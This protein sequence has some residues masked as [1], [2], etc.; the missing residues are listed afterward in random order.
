LVEEFE[1]FPL[2]ETVDLLDALGYGPQV[3]VAPEGSTAEYQEPDEDKPFR[4]EGIS[5][6]TGY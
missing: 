3:W 4:H 5:S 1:S 6:Y 2:G